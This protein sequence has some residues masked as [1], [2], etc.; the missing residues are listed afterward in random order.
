MSLLKKS[1]FDLIAMLSPAWRDNVVNYEL[2]P[3]P[4]AAGTQGDT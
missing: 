4:D 2:T 3:F 1:I